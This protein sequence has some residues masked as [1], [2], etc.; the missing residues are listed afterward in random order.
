MAIK[1]RLAFYSQE[2]PSGCIEWTGAKRALGY[3]VTCVDAQV[4]AAHRVSW[5]ANR[6][7]IP[8][9]IWVLHRCDNP[10]CINPEHLFLGT[11]QDNTDDKIAKGRHPRGEQVG[12]L[13]PDDIVEIRNSSELQRVL[14]ERYGVVVQ[15]I[16]RIKRRELWA[17]IP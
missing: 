15:T 11:H 9:G 16:S 8:K 4:V 7:P 14:A 2:M 10:A 3:G 17:H 13:K 6:G 5:E 1:D 12:K